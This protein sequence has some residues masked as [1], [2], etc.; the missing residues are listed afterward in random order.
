MRGIDEKRCF[1]ILRIMKS[2]LLLF[3]ETL[4]SNFTETFEQ[5]FGTKIER[6]KVAYIPNAR[7]LTNLV[8][9]QHATENRVR[10]EKLGFE[11]EE[12]DLLKVDRTQLRKKLESKDVIWMQGGLVSNLIKAI[13]YSGLR[14]YINKLLTSGLKYVGSSAGSMIIGNNLDSAAW[15][16]S[17]NDIAVE[18]L[19]GLG[20]VDFQIVPHYN[21][22][23]GSAVKEN[24]DPGEQYYLLTDEQAI[25]VRGSEIVFYGGNVQMYPENNFMS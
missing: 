11:V 23:F 9:R 8:K 21:R 5:F 1:D 20:L 13:D 24:A 17:E 10:I 15:F 16:P 2:E 22:N 6:L 18:G 14:D 3:S 4:E 25:G 12:I 19:H 7:D